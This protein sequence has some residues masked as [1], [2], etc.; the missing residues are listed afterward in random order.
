MGGGRLPEEV[1]R[2]PTFN[3]LLILHRGKPRLR[4]QGDLP[5]VTLL[6]KNS[7]QMTP[8]NRAEREVTHALE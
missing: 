4:E 6:M 2:P 5:G 8:G 3:C 1:W 7:V